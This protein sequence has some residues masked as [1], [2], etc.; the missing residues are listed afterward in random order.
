MGARD[1]WTEVMLGMGVETNNPRTMKRMRSHTKNPFVEMPISECI[2]C[3]KAV[4]ASV[5]KLV[6]TMPTVKDCVVCA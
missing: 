5:F 1:F 3:R 4:R 2:C 6:A